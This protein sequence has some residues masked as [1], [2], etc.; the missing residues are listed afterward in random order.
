[1]STEY[2]FRQPGYC[3]ICERDVEFTALYDWFRDH[4]LCS[5]CGS[6]PRERALMEAIKLYY[7]KYAKLKIHESSPI[8]RGVSLRLAKECRNYSISHYLPDVPPGEMCKKHNARSESLEAM[9]FLPETFDLL[10]TQDV[11]EHVFD[12]DAAFREI[13][14]I[15]KPGGAHIFTVP[16]VRKNEPSRRRALL[17]DDGSITHYFEPEYHGNPVDDQGSLVTMDW[18]YDIVRHIYEASGMGSHIIY[19]NDIDRGVQAEYIDVV[20]SF[21]R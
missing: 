11:M 15:L 2:A 16:I 5:K 17:G 14:R 9:T 3:T 8:G 19:M 13:A 6:V 7:P 12:P 20:V 4:L 18:G 21:K 1:M 10:I